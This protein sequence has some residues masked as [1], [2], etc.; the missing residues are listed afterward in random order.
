M[1]RGDG[2]GFAASLSVVVYD[3]RPA[4]SCSPS[5]AKR[6]I[7]QRK[8]SVARLEQLIAKNLAMRRHQYLDFTI[9][10]KPKIDQMAVEAASKWDGIKG[11]FTNNFGMR[12]GVQYSLLVNTTAQP[13]LE[14]MQIG[15]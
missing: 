5:R 8:R 12:S 6:A 3:A 10:Q 4:T 15:D 2:E 1:E 9:K 7:S 11:Y 14:D 13:P